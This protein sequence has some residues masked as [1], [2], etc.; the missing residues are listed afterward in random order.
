MLVQDQGKFILWR[1]GKGN[2]IDI[3]LLQTFSKVKLFLIFYLEYG[4][5]NVDNLL[6]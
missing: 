3:Y 2:S 1:N 4:I 5:F 6:S